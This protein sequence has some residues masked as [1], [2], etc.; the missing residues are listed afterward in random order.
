MRLGKGRIQP[1]GL[2]VAG[3][4]PL[5]ES[6][7]EHTDKAQVRLRLGVVRHQRNGLGIRRS[8]LIDFS[9]V[10]KL[11]APSQPAARRPGSGPPPPGTALSSDRWNRAVPS[12]LPA[13]MPPARPRTFVAVHPSGPAGSEPPRIQGRPAQ[14]L[15]QPRDRET[16]RRPGQVPDRLARTSA[17][18]HEP[19]RFG[20]WREMRLESPPCRIPPSSLT[21][22]RF[23]SFNLAATLSS[24]ANPASLATRGWADET[25]RPPAYPAAARGASCRHTG[26]WRLR[27]EHSE[28]R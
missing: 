16:D 20:K 11:G 23:A 21:S 1:D 4:R 14:G 19:G 7:L 15:P 13:G 3:K 10:Q 22:I 26:Y 6:P 18:S 24:R 9:P 17:I 27:P 28:I 5:R 8:P 2:P 12:R 25:H